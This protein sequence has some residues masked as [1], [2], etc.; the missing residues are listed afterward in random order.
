MNSDTCGCC[1]G[2]TALTPVSLEN[3]PGLSA[4]AYRVGTH[5][6]FKMTMRAALSG[7]K[8]LDG[9]TSRDDDDP[10][11]ALIDAWACVLDVLTFYQERIANEGYLLTASERSSVLEL[12]RAIGYELK[13]GVA[14]GTFL[15]FTVDDAPGT[16]GYAT[17]DT[18]VKVMSIPGQNEKPQ[19]FETVEKIDAKAVWNALTPRLTEPKIPGFG[20]T[21]IY[22]KGTVTGLK[23]GDG[24]LFVG[25]EREDDPGSERWDFR[26]VKTAVAD[27]AAGNTKVTW[28]K[29]LGWRRGH[30]IIMP[31]QEN[32]KVYAFRKQAALF[33]YNAPD[34]RTMPD[35]IKKN[36]IIPST[37]TGTGLYAEY[38]NNIDPNVISPTVIRIDPQVNFDWGSAGSPDPAINHEN[39]SGR[40]TGFVQPDSTG[41]YT[42]YTLSDDGVKLWVDGK[43]IVNNWTDHGTTEDSGTISLAAGHIYD[44]KLEYYQ[45]SGAAVI[46]LFWQGPDQPKEIIPKN[47][48]YIPDF[49]QNINEWPGL[50][51]SSIGNLTNNIICLDAVYQQILPDSW[52]LLSIPE[53]Q[54]LYQ[55][56]KIAEESKTDFTL[57]GKI[58]RVTLSGEN[59]NLYDNKLRQT[60]VFAQSEQLDIAEAPR[61]D[62]LTGNVIELDN[63]VP[64]LVKGK[65]LIISGKRM[66]ALVTQAGLEIVSLDGEKRKP[67]RTGDVL[68][69]LEP[70]VNN[71]DGSVSWKLLDR[72]GFTGSVNTLPDIIS[73]MPAEKDDVAVSEVAEIDGVFE[74]PTPEML[75]VVEFG[76]GKSAADAAKAGLKR[77]GKGEAFE[78]GYYSVAGWNGESYAALKGKASKLARIIIEQ[79]ENEVMAVNKGGVWNIGGGWKLAVKNI[80][81]AKAQL[82]LTKDDGGENKTLVS[83]GKVYTYESSIDGETDVPL[84]VTYIDDI[85]AS[86][87]RLKYTWVVDTNVLDI[88]IGDNV[89]DNA[90]SGGTILVLKEPMANSYDPATVTIYANV[91]RATHGETVHEVMGSG[92]GALAN[93]SFTLKKPPLTYVSAPTPS[94][95]LSTLEV[96]VNDVKWQEM[97]SLYG[98]D[99]R[100]RSYITRIADDGSATVI[101]GDG[102]SGARLPT[103]QENIAATYRT[104]IGMQGMVKAGQLSL[105]MTRPLGVK[106]VT[107]PLAPTGA[108]DPESRDQARQNAPQKV[109]TLDRIVSL[110]DFEDFT[111]AFA[112]IGKAQATWLRD[113]EVRFVHITVASADAGSVDKTSDLYKNLWLG[114]ENSKDPVQQFRIDSFTPLSFNLSASVLVDEAYIKEKVLAAVTD[115]LNQAFSFEQ[116]S[117]GQSVTESEVVAVMQGVE[118]VSAVS[119]NALYVKGQLPALN[120]Y[121]K[122]NRA[123]LDNGT[124]SPAEL[125][126]LNPDGIELTEMKT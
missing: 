8:V 97:D 30:S 13:P 22:L 94:G 93:Q 103:G 80:I 95:T 32:L 77:T 82:V 99:E 47:H 104:G 16:P 58:T 1:K 64:G 89:S 45:H 71:A 42:F 121:L 108:A 12:A 102:K 54:E 27:M 84:F 61:T 79:D 87:V 48:L 36:Y 122:A 123:S 67:L 111:R 124:L 105:L 28:E 126:T 101:F 100:A 85:G 63:L 74:K 114:I 44:I 57:T 66:R 2:I 115:A 25:K 78:N 81:A 117:F 6:S 59:L 49:Y 113:G 107:N 51:I 65:L 35:S 3:L 69:V 76:F 7:E 33:G 26:L 9:L 21:E 52:L 18:G 10:S 15:A 11:I 106:G 88:K 53:Y 116:R 72:D 40:W 41:I 38:F 92:S 68:W 86:S 29:G 112:G 109:L 73:Q 75:K 110:Q 17:I 37:G 39:F 43:L 90:D 60:V 55:V 50:T 19:T 56:K 83:K 23:P 119:L 34:W 31:A 120:A 5:G 96:R 70:S 98:L 24:L 118:G 20:D 125:L 4:L 91:A 46:K 62:M 14:A